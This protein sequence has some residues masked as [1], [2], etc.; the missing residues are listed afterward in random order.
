MVGPCDVG[1]KLLSYIKSKTFLDYM[2]EE[3]LC[4]TALVINIIAYSRYY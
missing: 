3:G 4:S 1:Q 2:C